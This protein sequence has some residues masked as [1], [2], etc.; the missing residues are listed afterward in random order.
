MQLNIKRSSG[1]VQP[2]VDGLDAFIHQSVIALLKQIVAS[3]LEKR[4]KE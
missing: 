2:S 1:Y 4:K 3:E